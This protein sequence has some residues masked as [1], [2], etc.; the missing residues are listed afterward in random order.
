MSALT[1]VRTPS[2]LDVAWAVA[3][4]LLILTGLIWALPLVFWGARALVRFLVA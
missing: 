2:R 3:S 4:D 1:P